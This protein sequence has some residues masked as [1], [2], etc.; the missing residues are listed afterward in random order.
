MS[1]R[2]CQTVFG[3]LL[4]IF[5]GAEWKVVGNSLPHPTSSH[6][7]PHPEHWL[8][9]Y[10]NIIYFKIYLLLTTREFRLFFQ[11]TH[12]LSHVQCKASE[13]VYRVCIIETMTIIFFIF[14]HNLCCYRFSYKVQGKKTKITVDVTQYI[15][16]YFNWNIFV[17]FVLC[18]F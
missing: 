15:D 11:I 9:E 17:F 13:S 14:P 6:P 3:H 7:I 10:K 18:V 2:I 4:I 12:T 8:F 5:A 1:A 16:T